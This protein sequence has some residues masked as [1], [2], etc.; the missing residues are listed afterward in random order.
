MQEERLGLCDYL[1]TQIMQLRRQ[2]FSILTSAEFLFLILDYFLIVI[3]GL[4]N[5][6]GF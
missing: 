5:V 2:V 3:S 6:H 1:I 4:E